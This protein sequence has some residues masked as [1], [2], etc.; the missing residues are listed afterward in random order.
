MTVK[1]KDLNTQV[2]TTLTVPATVMGG[3]NIFTT[4]SNITGIPATSNLQ[5]T[6]ETGASNTMGFRLDN[7]RIDG[8]RP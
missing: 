2:E 6:F 3:A 5:I 7:V 1:I 8:E 4:V